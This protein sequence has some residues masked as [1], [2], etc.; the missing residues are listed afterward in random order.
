MDLSKLTGEQYAKLVQRTFVSN[1]KNKIDSLTEME[2]RMEEIFLIIDRAVDPYRGSFGKGHEMQDAARDASPEW[3]RKWDNSR[4]WI[5][6]LTQGW[7]G[8]ILMAESFGW[9]KKTL[10]WDL[11]YNYEQSNSSN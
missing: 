5:I 6:C 2:S 7:E 8:L 3:L 9:D 11:T 1:E 10:L 4:R